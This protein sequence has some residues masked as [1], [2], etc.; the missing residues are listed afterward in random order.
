MLGLGN[1]I[2]KTSRAADKLVFTYT[3][4]FDDDGTGWVGWS[5]QGG[6]IS[7]AYDQDI[8]SGSGGGW[9][10]CTYPNTEQTNESGIIHTSMF[11]TVTDA[12]GQYI[13]ASC[14]L[15]LLSGFSNPCGVTVQAEMDYN[16]SPLTSI[17]TSKI[18]NLTVTLGPDS[19]GSYGSIFGVLFTQSGQF[20][21]ANAVFYISDLIVKIYEPA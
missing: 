17:D 8:P 14:K 5:V 12:V 6:S 4:D 19:D 20:P 11:N 2:P 1:S 3:D 18:Q 9:M 13:K 10:K 16:N 21:Q 7:F 15:Y